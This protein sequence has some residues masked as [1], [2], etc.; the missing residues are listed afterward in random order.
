MHP[1]KKYLIKNTIDKRTRTNLMHLD[2]TNPDRKTF[3][4]EN[5]TK[6]QF[7]DIK[8]PPRVLGNSGRTT[9]N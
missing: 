9:I 6:P 7:A 5:Q 4:T 3:P 1:N 8:R 2:T